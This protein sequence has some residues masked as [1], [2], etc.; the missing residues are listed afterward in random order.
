MSNNKAT[1]KISELPSTTDFFSGNELIEISKPIINSNNYESK[2]SSISSVGSWLGNNLQLSELDN[3]TVVEAINSLK[4]LGDSAGSHNAIYRGKW[5]GAAPTQEQYAAIFN[6]TFDDLYIG[7]FWSENPNDPA[8]TRW[9]IAGFNYYTGTGLTTTVLT[10][11]AVIIPDLAIVTN[12]GQIVDSEGYSSLGGYKY[13]YARGYK[14]VTT[15][16][17]TTEDNQLSFSVD[18]IPEYVSSVHTLFSVNN[19]SLRILWEIDAEHTGEDPNNPGHGIITIY[20]GNRYTIFGGTTSSVPAIYNGIPSGSYVDLAYKY[21]EENY[22]SLYQAETI[23]NNVFGSEHI[24]HHQI[25]LSAQKVYGMK[26]GLFIGGNSYYKEWTD[27]KIEVPT[28]ECILGN[29]D[30]SAYNEYLIQ[31]LGRQRYDAENYNFDT[32]SYIY[33]FS[34]PP[35]NAPESHLEMNQL[36]LFVYDPALIHTRHGYWFRNLGSNMELKWHDS[37]SPTFFSYQVKYLLMDPYGNQRRDPTYSYGNTGI[38]PI[39]CISATS[40]P[41]VL[42]NTI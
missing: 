39:F 9:R 33:D 23:I 19:E 41:N 18:H 20:G 1:Y 30:M 28:L 3:Q 24:M 25:P 12:N 34:L 38:R 7:D 21:K 14:S 4:K 2:K 40:E 15:G 16:V 22:G 37:L 13:S 29:A 8:Y 6:G 5:L 10:N 11:H 42:P 26:Q 35:L 31:T 36:P 32:S 27:T 17:T